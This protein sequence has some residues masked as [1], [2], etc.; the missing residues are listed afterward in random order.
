MI[1]K[2]F[3]GTKELAE[4]LDVAAGTLRVWVCHKKIPYVKVGR[5]VKFDLQKIEKWIKEREVKT[6]RY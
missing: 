5:L 4:Y 1:E 2:R 3:V 6:I